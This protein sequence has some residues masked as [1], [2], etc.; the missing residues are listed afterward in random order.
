[1]R[2]FKQ[3][4][5][6]DRP[7][8]RGDIL[9]FLIFKTIIVFQVIIFSWSWAF[10]ISQ[11]NYAV[12][13]VGIATWVNIS[14]MF[15]SPYAYLNAGA[16]TLFAI[17]GYFKKGRIFYLL[18][19]LGLHLQY[20]ARFSQGKISHGANFTGMAL[21]ILALAAL[22]FN[23]QEQRRKI[24]LGLFIFFVALAYTSAGFCKLIGSGIHWADGN[25]LILWI[26]EGANDTLSQNGTFKLNTFQ[27]LILHHG[28]L[29]TLMLTLGLITELCGF[30]LC[31][32]KTRWIEASLL[33]GMHIGIVFSMNIGFTYIL[34]F[35]IIIGYPWARVF[36]LMI[37]DVRF[38]I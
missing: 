25:H 3:L 27:Q 38:A 33:L 19:F 10:Y 26:R 1:M 8:T 28:W 35:L 12:K 36:G 14:F 16:I 5:S 7:E 32:R 18:A 37:D 23:D 4:F 31:F 29:G 9:V 30:L 20:A 15:G 22:V 2:F 17:L 6:V 11:L 34:A 21:L 24:T 13:L